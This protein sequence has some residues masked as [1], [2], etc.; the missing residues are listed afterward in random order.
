MMPET[1]LREFIQRVVERDPA[2]I[3]EDF[4]TRLMFQKVLHLAQQA[5]LLRSPH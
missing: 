1:S 2:R 4:S 5:G 3:P